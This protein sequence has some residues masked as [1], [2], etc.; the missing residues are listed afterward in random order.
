MD[1]VKELKANQKYTKVVEQ[2]KK[3]EEKLLELREKKRKLAAN[4][5]NEYHEPSMVLVAGN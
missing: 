2:L 4:I 3:T 5:H 1:S